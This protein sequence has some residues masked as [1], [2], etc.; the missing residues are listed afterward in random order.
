MN[1]LLGIKKGMTST[2]DAR[3][4]RVGATVLEV[5][6]NVITQVKL[7]HGKDGYD[8]VQLVYGYKKSAKKPQTGLVKKLNIE[9]I[10]R[11]FKEVKT[12]DTKEK[13]PGQKIDLAQVFSFGDALKVTGVSKGKGF[14]GGI[15]RHG[16]AGGPKTHGQSDRHRAPGSIGA[17]TTPGRVYKGKRMAGHMGVQTVSVSNLEVI[18]VDQQNNL[19]IVK[20]AIPGHSG[21]LVTITKLGK[22]K[23][24]ISPPEEKS[25]QI[26]TG[27]ERTEQLES[28]NLEQ[29]TDNNIE[30]EQ[31]AQS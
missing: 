14:Q 8:A 23:G 31:N 27:H 6:P 4:R 3:H 26:E 10:N 19:I 12:N 2:Y 5:K 20:G 28:E 25:E 24:Y 21:A 1:T 29:K 9:G 11:W 30:G 22:I 16:F 17:G 13:K 7:K 15:R 18:S